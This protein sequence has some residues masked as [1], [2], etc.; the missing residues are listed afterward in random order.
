MR[1]AL[2]LRCADRSKVER[3]GGGEGGG[4]GGGDPELLLVVQLKQH[5]QPAHRG[6]RTEAVRR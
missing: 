1:A 2:N 6:Q 3:E 4:G 5:Q